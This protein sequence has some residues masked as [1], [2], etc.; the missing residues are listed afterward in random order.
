MQFLGSGFKREGLDPGF[1]NKILNIYP[2]NFT[3]P[4]GARDYKGENL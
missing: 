2:T 1:P 4:F 3:T